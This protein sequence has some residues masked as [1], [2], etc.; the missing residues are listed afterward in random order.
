MTVKNLMP[1]HPLGNYNI[2]HSNTSRKNLG[3][4]FKQSPPTFYQS[5]ENV[6]ILE[7]TRD[8]KQLKRQQRQVS[9]RG[10]DF[11]GVLR[12]RLLDEP[13]ES[14]PLDGERLHRLQVDVAARGLVVEQKA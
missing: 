14:K 7:S 10:P 1:E 8:Q 11:P 13:Q 5:S 4:T 12:A 9:N 2:G 6:L 3:I